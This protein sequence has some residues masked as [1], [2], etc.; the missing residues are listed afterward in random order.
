MLL[1]RALEVPGF[2]GTVCLCN[3]RDYNYAFSRLLHKFPREILIGSALVM[4]P[5]LNQCCGQGDGYTLIGRA[6]FTCPTVKLG[7]D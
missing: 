1:K 2:L 7:N 4:L 5:S 3:I 6:W